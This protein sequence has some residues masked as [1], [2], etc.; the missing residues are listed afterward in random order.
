MKKIFSA[1]AL[2]SFGAFSYASDNFT[3]PENGASL[4]AVES[5]VSEVWEITS[6]M[7][8][9]T[10]SIVLNPTYSVICVYS[11]GE[12]T[13]GTTTSSAVAGEMAE[14]CVNSGGHTFFGG[15]K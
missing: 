11:D 9:Q 13:Q 3:T 7:S 10:Q 5:S 14:H 15:N 4:E 6:T 1:S 2:I 12:Y 8:V